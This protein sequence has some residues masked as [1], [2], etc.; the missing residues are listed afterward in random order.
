MA[1]PNVFYSPYSDRYAYSADY[2][3]SG[4]Y[5]LANS[6][7]WTTTSVPHASVTEMKMKQDQGRIEYEIWKRQQRDNATFE[8][9]RLIDAE[10]NLAIERAA[11]EQVSRAAMNAAREAA[12]ARAALA[13]YEAMAN[14]APV[15]PKPYKSPLFNYPPARPRWVFTWPWRSPGY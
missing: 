13:K 7:T 14:V 6:A 12:D 4:G 5:G 15:A 1:K 10:K 11:R 8:R 9:Q 2:A 3:T